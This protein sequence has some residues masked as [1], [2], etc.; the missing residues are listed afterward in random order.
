[1]RQQLPQ[2]LGECYSE[3]MSFEDD[4]AVVRLRYRPT[5]NL[6]EETANPHNRHM[7]VIT[8]GMQGDSGYKDA[9]GSAVPFRAG[10]TTITSFQMSLGERR[11]E[12][13][14]TVS[15]L[16][17]LIGESMLNRYIGE[18]RT[19][20]LLGNGN[21][22]QLAFQKT[23]AASNSHASALIHYLNQGVTSTLDMHIHTLSLLSEQLKL[24]APSDCAVKL[25]F[26]ATDIEKLDRARDIMIEQMDQPLTIPYLCAAVGLNEF[27]LKEGMHYRFNSTP[28][29]MLHEIRMRKAYTLLESGCQVAQAAYRVGY[30]F[31]NNF[32]A[33]FTRF[34]GK[35]PKSVFGKRR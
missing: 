18:Q 1:M 20:Q 11:Y 15:Q 26:S 4:L 3:R 19:R 13:G 31:P 16:R 28:H 9:D 32:S 25:P 23:S 2:D 21:V 10:Y 22:R 24:L 17:L 5:H 35:T 30:K 33:A 34:F 12:A 14:A 8:Y 7:L 29:R 6:I 27:K